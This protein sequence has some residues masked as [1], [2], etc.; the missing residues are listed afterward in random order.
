MQ[1][2]TKLERTEGADWPETPMIFPNGICLE[3]GGESPQLL[4][5]AITGDGKDS[6]YIIMWILDV[7][8]GKW[9][10]V[11]ELQCVEP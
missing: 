6:N 1:N 11:S 9:R 7:N 8:A 3:Y 10:K 2:W 4:V 5:M